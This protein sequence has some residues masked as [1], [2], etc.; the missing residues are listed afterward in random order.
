MASPPSSAIDFNLA[1][2]AA[3]YWARKQ[4]VDPLLSSH[5]RRNLLLLR[6]L[7]PSGEV[8]LRRLVANGHGGGEG[9]RRAD[10]RPRTRVAPVYS[11]Q[12]S[13]ITLL[14]SVFP[15]P[16]SSLPLRCGWWPDGLHLLHPQPFCWA[17][18][19]KEATGRGQVERGSLRWLLR[20]HLCCSFSIDIM[21][22][23]R[24]TQAAAGGDPVG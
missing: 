4:H 24:Y 23:R 9:T 5:R 3:F 12:T 20:H 14:G 18:R 22:T 19:Q 10:V 11:P 6:H 17:R 7:H 8:C 21:H 16:C 15:I 1:C 13:S 2:G